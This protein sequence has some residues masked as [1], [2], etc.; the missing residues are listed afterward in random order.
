M[1]LQDKRILVTGGS[2]FLGRQVVAQLI[3]A[4]AN[5]DKITVPRSRDVDLRERDAC[6]RAA[7]GQ[8]LIVHLAAH[9]GGIG[10]N[11][12]K[13]A[14]LF[15]D[16]L[17]MGTQLIHE[18]YLAD[19]EKFVCVGTICAYPKFTPVPFKEDDLWNGYPEETN[20]P[21]GVAKKALLVQLQAY[22]DQYGFNGI[23]LLPVNLYGPGDNFDPRSSHVIPALVRKVYEAKERKEQVLP[24]W[25]DG[26]PTREFLYVD[27]AARGIV[28]GAQHYDGSEPVNLGTGS[29]VPI[30]ELVQQI[31]ELMEFQGEILWETDQP[32]GQPRRCLD[33]QRAQ[34]LFGF[35]AQVGLTEGLRKTIHWYQ[36]HHQPV[37]VA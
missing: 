17:M 10:L 21:Y 11:R 14:E 1:N 2:G 27:D 16:N 3:A 15:Y 25:G 37:P 9:V 33:T 23:Y 22:R 30:R 34:K 28:M 8:D 19:V 13:P 29:E 6:R 18:A 20:A 31:S 32:N 7:A 5:P 12:E 36:E 4:G 26:S 35:Q 24:V